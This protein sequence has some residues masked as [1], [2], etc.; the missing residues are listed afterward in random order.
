MVLKNDVK[1]QV[2][3]YP[4]NKFLL[5]VKD[6]TDPNA[7]FLTNADIYDP[8]TFIGRKSFLGRPHY[9][10][11]YGVNP[12]ERQ[13]VKAYIL[14]SDDAIQSIKLLKTN[15]IQYVVLYKHKH[16]LT[17]QLKMVYQDDA[18]LVLQVI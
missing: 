3:D 5:W 6:H 11:A 12:G 1:T 18:H 17:Q 14:S 7:V 10:W 8:I 13:T 9:L 4:N 2:R 15:K 16:P